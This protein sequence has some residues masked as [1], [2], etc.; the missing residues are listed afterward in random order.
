ML[1]EKS[2]E[3][4]WKD[5]PG[6]EGHYQ[7][8]NL[9][10]IRSVSRKWHKRIHVLKTHENKGYLLV[11]LYKD[12]TSKGLYVHRLVA[13]TFLDNKDSLP[14]VNHKDENRQNNNLENLE[15]C[16]YSYNNN[17]K[18]INKRRSDSLT[19]GKT[20]KK[21]LQYSLDNVLIREWCSITEIER[22]LGYSHGNIVSCCQGRYG[23]KTA[24]G[25]R[26]EYKKEAV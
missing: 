16:S 18:E 23:F 8:S 9:G 26:W 5:I 14:C 12:S 11:W 2:M 25:Y 19:N 20:S 1:K 15:W 21:V 4:I 10:R 7:A 22:E 6:Y 13:L 24:Y 3:E 17:Y